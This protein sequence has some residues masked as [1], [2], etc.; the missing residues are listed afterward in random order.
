MAAKN[1]AAQ[2]RQAAEGAWSNPYVQRVAED[3]ELRANVR[4]ALES[5]RSAYGR[6][7]NGKPVSK[8]VAGDKRFQKDVKQASQSLR[9][10]SDALREGP[11]KRK[12]RFGLGRLLLLT[13]VGGGIALAVSEPLR[14]KVL[15]ALFGAEEEFDYQSTTTSPP[16]PP[17]PAA[18]DASPAESPTSTG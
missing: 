11:K 16:P 14:N 6:L 15:D 9:D 2:A 5:A 13:I 4:A 1:K 10:A 8:V 17:P 18:S 3:P 7:T 12:R